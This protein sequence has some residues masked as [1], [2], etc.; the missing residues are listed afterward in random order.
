MRTLKR[1]LCLTIIVVLAGCSKPETDTEIDSTSLQAKTKVRLVP[2]SSKVVKRYWDVGAD[3]GLTAFLRRTCVRNVSSTPSL[4]WELD[5]VRGSVVNEFHLITINPNKVITVPRLN[6]EFPFQQDPSGVWYLFV[7][8][9]ADVSVD[10]VDF[11][12]VYYEFVTPTP[13]GITSY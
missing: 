2:R 9:D 10:W 12:G 8:D 13:G 4:Y 5:R 3:E 6:Q 11:N 1:V 7:R